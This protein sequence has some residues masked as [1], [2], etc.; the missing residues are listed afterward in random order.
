MSEPE[1]WALTPAQFLALLERNHLQE[2]R[3][4]YGAAMVCS[5]IANANRDPRKRIKPYSPLDFLPAK[6]DKGVQTL[7][8]QLGTVAAINAAL[9]GSDERW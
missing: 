1:F 8:E 5:T 4:L 3:S 2:E 7:E 9:G 6:K